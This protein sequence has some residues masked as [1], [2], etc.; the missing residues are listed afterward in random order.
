M[1]RISDEDLKIV[2]AQLERYPKNVLEVSYRCS[3]GFPMVIKSKPVL[4]GKP[5]P[6]IYW[7]TCPYL[8][9]RV[10]QLEANGDIPKYEKLLSSSKNL[11]DLQLK[12][13]SLA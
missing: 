5:F 8:R 6:T 12:A 13:H 4:E 1:V 10:S 3:F 7:L 2:S 9:Y 11:F